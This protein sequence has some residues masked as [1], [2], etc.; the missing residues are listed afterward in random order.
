MTMRKS[1][2]RRASLELTTRRKT[3]IYSVLTLTWLSGAVWLILHYFLT[4]RGEFGTEPN[5]FEFWM[6]ALHGACAFFVLWLAGWLWTTHITPWWRSNGRRR[7]SGVVMI[8]F[9]AILIISGY[10]LYYGSGDALRDWTAI[11]HWTIGLAA[12][13]PMIVHALRSARYR[14]P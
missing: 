9:S 8:S 5:R 11:V 1:I 12:A 7:V 13:V 3:L 14:R 2:S 4:E 10:L 6:L